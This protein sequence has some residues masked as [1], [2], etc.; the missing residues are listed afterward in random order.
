M[1]GGVG[2][3]DKPAGYARRVWI[4]AGPLPNF[5]PGSVPTEAQAA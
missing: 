1:N 5:A 4:D 2:V 3:G